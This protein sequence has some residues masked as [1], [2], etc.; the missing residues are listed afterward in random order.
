ML[1]LTDKFFHSNLWEP[2]WQD[3]SAAI[4][5]WKELFHSS[6]SR[7]FWLHFQLPVQNLHEQNKVIPSKH[8]DVELELLY[9]LF[10]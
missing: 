10:I 3:A 7:H 2:W 9:F 8:H 1:I 5:M 4:W 6:R